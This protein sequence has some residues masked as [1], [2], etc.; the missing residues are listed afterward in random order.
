M[1]NY[2][3]GK[4]YKICN[5]INDMIYIGSTAIPLNKRMSTH[6]TYTN[7]QYRK[8]VKLYKYMHELGMHNFNI[9][10][11]ENYSCNNREELLKHERYYFDIHNKDILLNSNKP[12]TSLI[13]KQQQNVKCSKI[14]HVNNR[15]YKKE[16]VMIQH[17]NN[18]EQRKIYVEK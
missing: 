9:V 5:N 12:C 13:E 15:E 17:K 7:K 6:R 18:K 11:I 1:P 8:N 14:W 16:K 10:L 3:N 4:I 2:K